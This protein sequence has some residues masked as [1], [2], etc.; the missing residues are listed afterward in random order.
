M[1]HAPSY[2]VRTSPAIR[3]E[4]SRSVAARKWQGA[5]DHGT[6][7]R[8]PPHELGSQQVCGSAVISTPKGRASR[9]TLRRWPSNRNRPSLPPQTPS[10]KFHNISYANYGSV[11][12]IAPLCT[13]GPFASSVHINSFGDSAL[14]SG[15]AILATPHFASPMPL[16]VT[17]SRV[18][19]QIAALDAC[20]A[21][22]HATAADGLASPTIRLTPAE[23]PDQALPIVGAPSRERARW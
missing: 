22:R 5:P 7:C 13:K 17:A 1:W 6:G 9:G 10:H 4:P 19:F 8:R 12:E 2:Q 16:F 3:S 14:S 11:L 20:R 15:W 21:K 18:C 23:T